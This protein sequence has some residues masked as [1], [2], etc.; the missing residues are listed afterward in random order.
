MTAVAYEVPVGSL[1]PH[2]LNPRKGNVKVI[3]ESLKVN[4]QYKP[5]LVNRPAMHILAGTHTWKAAKSLGWPTVGVTFVEVGEEQAIAILLADNRASDSG[6]TNESAA[7]DLLMALPSLEGT[8][9]SIED[10]H[11]PEPDMDSILGPDEGGSEGD[12]EERQESPKRETVPFVVG[13]VKGTYE[14]PTYDHWRKG[15]SPKSS[16]AFADICERLG[17]I[18]DA[19]L[20]APSEHPIVDVQMELLN[21][22]TPYPGN[23]R[24][25]DIGMITELL[26]AHGQFRPIV[27]SKNTRRILA[28]NHVAQ[29]AEGLGWDRVAVS[30]VTTDEDGERRIVLADNRTSDLADY[31]PA[32][33]GRALTAVSMF[34]L[35][36]TTG[37]ALEDLQDLLSG[38]TPAKPTTR[39]DAH[40]RIGNIKGK[41]RLGLLLDI[42]LTPGSELD[43][44]AAIIGL[45][46]EGIART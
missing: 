10:L 37:F 28:G 34:E 22:L 44:V 31:D 14:K 27:V 13:N 9:Y 3:A 8:G 33:L 40:I 6:L 7:R 26:K 25:G 23:P 4:G 36:R 1:K 5:I 19:P 42:N 16:A 30:W 17:L 35:E 41:V 24:Q 29:A 46:P 15:L 18:E 43:E 2:P 45:P 39:A 32:A 21:T 38:D 20:T 11:L 12:G